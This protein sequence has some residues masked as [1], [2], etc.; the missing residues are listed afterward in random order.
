ML[1][2]PDCAA[3]VK[4]LHEHEARWTP[5]APGLKFY[6]LGAASY[7]DEVS[8]Y[9]VR[10]KELNPWLD[11]IFAELYSA[12]ARE[13]TLVLGGKVAFAQDFARPGFHIWQVPGI[14]TSDEASLHFDLQYRRLPWPERAEPGFSRPISFTLPLRLPAQGS[15]LALWNVTA[16]GVNAFCRHTGQNMELDALTHLLERHNQRYSVGELVVHSGHQLHRIAPTPELTAG[17]ER[18]TLQGHGIYY[19]DTWH[20][21]W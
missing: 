21:Y 20:L 14:P 2:E 4:K 7:L 8:H 18:I 3:L 1:R 19:D 12:L 6:T 15:G 17:D 5:R 9:L 13:L 11:L 10:A 16:E